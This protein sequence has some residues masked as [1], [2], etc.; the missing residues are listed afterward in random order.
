[1][2]DPAAQSIRRCKRKLST[3]IGD[4]SST[5]L[6][7]VGGKRGERSGERVKVYRFEID[8]IKAYARLVLDEQVDVRRQGF[9]IDLMY[10]VTGV[11]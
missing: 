7:V 3:A 2:S 4:V 5:A 11:V 10:G 6:D 8:R 1:M 9:R